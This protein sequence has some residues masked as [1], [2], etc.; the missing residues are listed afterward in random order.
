MLDELRSALLKNDP[1]ATRAAMRNSSVMAKSRWST[2]QSKGLVGECPIQTAASPLCTAEV[3]A[4]VL[5]PCKT[6]RINDRQVP[7]LLY[8]AGYPSSL[9][10]E[11][12][13]EQMTKLELALALEPSAIYDADGLGRNAFDLAASNGWIQLCEKLRSAGAKVHNL[14]DQGYCAMY[15]APD[16][17]TVEYLIGLGYSAQETAVNGDTPLHRVRNAGAVRKLREH[18]ADPNAMNKDGLTPLMAVC[19]F[20]VAESLIPV[21]VE[22]G[23]DPDLASPRTGEIPLNLAYQTS[24]LKFLLDA[25]SDPNKLNGRGM[26]PAH[27]IF[28]RFRRLV[29]DQRGPPGTGVRP[30]WD[31]VYA[32]LKL[33][34]A[35]GADIQA[36]MP[37]TG[38][39]IRQEL[40]A[41]GLSAEAGQVEALE[42]K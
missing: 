1:E 9:S 19:Q 6:L 8:I 15:S 41:Y 25:G 35:H 28:D 27:H 16:A 24:T 29:L 11:A 39:T 40:L 23:A 31:D 30:T 10:R 37:R 17:A 4:E 20:P 7:I 26:S 36:Q 38:R 34:V 14:Y 42:R 2:Q 22:L 32:Q 13:Q 33:L 18:G 21:L 12:Q 3:F 5:T